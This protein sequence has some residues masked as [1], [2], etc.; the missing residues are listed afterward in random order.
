MD[1]ITE[2]PKSDGF[3]AIAVFVDHDVTKAAVFAPCHSTITADGTATL[4]RNHV[5]KRFGLPHKLISD[6]GPQFTAAFTHD[7]CSLLNIDQALSTAYHPQSDGQTERVNQELEQY[8]CAYTSIQQNNWASHLSTAEF[9]HNIR[10][11]STT[12]QSPFYAL[13]GFHPQS[14]PLDIPASSIPDVQTRLDSLSTLRSDLLA[15]Q[16]LA[17]QSWPSSSSPVPYHVGDKVWLEGKNISTLAPSL[18]L[19]P[20][21]YG[22]FPILSAV[23]DVTFRLLRAERSPVY[24]SQKGNLGRRRRLITLTR[25]WTTFGKG[26]QLRQ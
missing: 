17:H 1:F 8:L 13:M 5:W 26:G 4:Y 16:T 25:K 15:T 11:H 9:A 6:R 20:R 7:L 19:T 18:K 23:N 12:S 3:D 10:T 14:L 24:A 2:L 22:P 21:R